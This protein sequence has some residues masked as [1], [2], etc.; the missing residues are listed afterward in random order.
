MRAL[1]FLTSGL[2]VF[3][4]LAIV[5]RT[6]AAGGGAAAIGVIVG[7]LFVFAGAGRLWVLVKSGEEDERDA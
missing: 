1:T 5:V 6:V 2:M 4:G 7:A 3:I